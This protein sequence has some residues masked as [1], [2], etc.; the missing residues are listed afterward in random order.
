[1]GF[2]SLVLFVVMTVLSLGAELISN[3]KPLLA[4]Y[5]GRWFVPLVQNLPETVFGGDFDTPTDFL[6]PYIQGQFAKQATG[7]FTPSTPT[8]TAP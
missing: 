7:R 5:D 6:D 3:D 2:A 4:R 1:M 8:T